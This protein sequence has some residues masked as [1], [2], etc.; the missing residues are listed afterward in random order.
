MAVATRETTLEA[1]ERRFAELDAEIADLTRQID[2]AVREEFLATEEQILAAPGER[3]TTGGATS[4]VAQIR[5]RVERLEASRATATRERLARE[6][7]LVAERQRVEQEKHAGLIKAAGRDINQAREKIDG[8]I[9]GLLTD[10]PAYKDAIERGDRTPG[11][12][13]AR[14]EYATLEAL[15]AE[16][17]V[18]AQRAAVRRLLDLVGYQA[19][20]AGQMWGSLAVPDGWVPAAGFGSASGFGSAPEGPRELAG[21]E[22]RLAAA[23]AGLLTDAGLV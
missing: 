15:L 9:A 8:H 14:R 7:L 2:E 21:Q 11:F 10:W 3:V 23:A 13:P 1:M 5:M 17:A 16:N 6:P 12:T 18:G 20:R 22:D 19:P 4:R